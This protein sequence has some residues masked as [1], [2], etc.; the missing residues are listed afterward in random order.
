[1]NDG[2]AGRGV[3]VRGIDMECVVREGIGGEPRRGM[4]YSSGGRA[5]IG[6][7]GLGMDGDG[8]ET[9]RVQVMRDKRETEE[10]RAR[11]MATS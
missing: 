5:K 10:K 11:C 9:D 8:G 7:P 3:D 1:M 2:C 6:R 4:K